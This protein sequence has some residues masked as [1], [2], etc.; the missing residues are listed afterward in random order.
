MPSIKV[1]SLVSPLTFADLCRIE[2]RLLVLAGITNTIL[3]DS[4]SVSFCA[5]HLWFG[6]AGCDRCKGGLKG[7]LIQLV[8]W[9]AVNPDLR[10]QSA[11]DVAYDH[12]YCLLP[13]CRNCSCL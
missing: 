3:Y 13:P 4:E 11:Y 7:K 5:N 1:S 8:G 9:G 2:P 10:H 6:C 12:L